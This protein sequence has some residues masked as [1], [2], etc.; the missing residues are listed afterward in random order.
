MAR[1]F[2]SLVPAAYLLLWQDEKVLLLRRYNT[3]YQDGNYSL[4]AGH[5]EP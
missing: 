2:H 1:D 5:V 3:S 4:I